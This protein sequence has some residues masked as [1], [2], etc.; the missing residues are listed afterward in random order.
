MILPW[1]FPDETTLY[2]FYNLSVVRILKEGD[3]RRFEIGGN[4]LAANLVND[5]SNNLSISG[6]T[7][8][9]VSVGNQTNSQSRSIRNVKLVYS[10]LTLSLR[11]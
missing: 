8:P 1:N 9:S 11:I 7:Y 10:V 2:N 4:W 3:K 5:C 6:F